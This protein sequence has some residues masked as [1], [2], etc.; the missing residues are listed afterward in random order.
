[1]S[2][3]VKPGGLI[4]AIEPRTWYDTPLD[5]TGFFEQANLVVADD[6]ILST[7]FLPSVLYL[8]SKSEEK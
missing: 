2:R 3:V 6:E 4:V 8:Y 7:Q 5:L 1:M